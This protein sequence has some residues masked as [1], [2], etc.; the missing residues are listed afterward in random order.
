MYTSIQFNKNIGVISPLFPTKVEVRNNLHNS[1]LF[2]GPA[3]PAPS[4]PSFQN[5]DTSTSCISHQ[6]DRMCH[7]MCFKHAM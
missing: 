2:R 6:E 5:S 1:Q 3:F 7:A 4:P